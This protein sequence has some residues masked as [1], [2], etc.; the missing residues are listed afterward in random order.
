M[1]GFTDEEIDGAIDVQVALRSDGSQP[2]KVRDAAYVATMAIVQCRAVALSDSGRTE[3]IPVSRALERRLP[4]G[5]LIT[6]VTSREGELIYMTEFNGWCS[7][8]STVDGC[9]E[10]LAKDEE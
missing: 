2:K 4:D 7:T 6:G 5:S 10:V 8:T 9:V 3:R 1:R